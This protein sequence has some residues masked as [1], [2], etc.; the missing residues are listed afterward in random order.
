MSSVLIVEDDEAV[1]QA[2]EV[3]LELHDIPY[4]SARSP[5][6][7][8]EAVASGSVGIV[9]QDMNFRPGATSGDEGAALFRAL[10]KGDPE[11][12]V[13]LM[14]AWASLET[15]VALVREGA[16]D[17]FGKPWDDA[18]LVSSLRNLLRLR[19]L[20]A[21]SAR[22]RTERSSSRAELAARYDLRGLVYESE[23]M[24]RVVSLAVKI[25]AADVPVLV[26]GPNGAGKERLAE[27]LQA[28]SRRSA[29]PFVKVNVGALPGELIES[30]L[31]GAEAGAYTGASRTR[32]GRFEAAQSGTLFLDEIG[33]LPLEGQVKL[34]RILQS[35]EFERLGSNQT[36]RVDVRVIG[37][38]N[39]DLPLAIRDGRFREDLYFR[40]NVVEL[41]VPALR[42]RPDDVL[43]LANAFL[44]SHSR[45]QGRVAPALSPSAQRMLL[46]HAWPGNVRELENRVRRALLVEPGDVLEPASLG[47]E[48]AAPP[49]GV[50]PRMNGK[51]SEES[52]ERAALE[53]LLVRHEG[54]VSQAAEELGLSRQA[55]YRRMEKLGITLERRPRD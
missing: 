46:S 26:T 19:A 30:E 32:P 15:A 14:T 5:A 54:R 34:L 29:G 16:T 33:T 27:I 6:E 2:L 1:A 21:E 45:A 40:L 42:D 7:A 50:R 24:H 28:N 22:R 11:L 51:E 53:A 18:K 25:A 41:L 52:A 55:F 43:P 38:T 39:T 3:L 44:S 23:A 17:Y 36:R 12:P 20:E 4:R 13:L 9:L 31:F 35:G 37:A 47:F 49:S 48:Q 10:R 8:L